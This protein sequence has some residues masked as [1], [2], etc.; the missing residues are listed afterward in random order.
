[1]VRV[2]LYLNTWHEPFPCILVLET[3]FP[4]HVSLGKISISCCL[5]VYPLYVSLLLAFYG[6]V[7]TIASVSLRVVRNIIR[8]YS[9]F[10]I[11]G[12][13]CV[14]M[15]VVVLLK[16]AIK[17]FEC[18]LL[19]VKLIVYNVRFAME[20]NKMHFKEVI[21]EKY[22]LVIRSKICL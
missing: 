14:G 7:S 3:F 15:S 8:K 5:G 19:S 18:C 12:C 10:F 16:N 17:E 9:L 20:S 4:M 22:V 6:L 1:M 13:V 2:I 11:M 21:K